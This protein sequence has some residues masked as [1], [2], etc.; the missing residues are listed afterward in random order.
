MGLSALQKAS[1]TD[2][3]LSRDLEA[4]GWMTVL[5]IRGVE[6]PVDLRDPLAPVFL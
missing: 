2:Y 6:E 1:A 4:A 5:R 3:F